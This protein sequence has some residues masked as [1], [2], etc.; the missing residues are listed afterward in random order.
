MTAKYN[1]LNSLQKTEAVAI[2]EE[3]LDPEDTM[4]KSNLNTS[5][6]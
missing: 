2:K 6:V 5:D 3:L 4:L 1:L